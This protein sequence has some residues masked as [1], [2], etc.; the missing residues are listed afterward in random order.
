MRLTDLDLQ[1]VNIGA[2]QLQPEA[3][4]DLFSGGQVVIVG[5]YTTPGSGE[6]HV[7][8]HEG[9]TPFDRTWVIDAPALA[10]N[11]DVIKYVWATEK[12]R[13][14]MASI[15]TGTPESEVRPQVEALGLAYRIQTP[16]THFSGDWGGVGGVGDGGG[17][18]VAGSTSPMWIGVVLL[19][20]R[21]RRR[22]R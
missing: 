14:L 5:R 19:F 9:A 13:A 7:T 6:V 22:L 16:Y 15:A 8:G 10:E 20:V 21:R 12:V 17:C 2:T 4:P 18:A 3:P 11:A 1:L